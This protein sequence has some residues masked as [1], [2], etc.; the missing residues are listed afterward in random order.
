VVGEGGNVP[1]IRSRAVGPRVDED[2][3]PPLTSIKAP[4]GPV[5][6]HQDA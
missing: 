6:H 2:S 4:R 1:R 3:G 5:L